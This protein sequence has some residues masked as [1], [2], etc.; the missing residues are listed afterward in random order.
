MQTTDAAEEAFPKVVANG[1]DA[2][3]N[4]TGRLPHTMHRGFGLKRLNH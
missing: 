2:V 4:D 1:T 3:V